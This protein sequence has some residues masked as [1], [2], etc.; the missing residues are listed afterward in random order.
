M[1]C[2]ACAPSTKT[3]TFFLC[4]ISAISA[5]GLTVPKTLETCATAISFVFSEI[6][7]G[8]FSICKTPLSEKGSLTIL[9]FFRCAAS[10]HGTRFEWCSISETIISSPLLIKASQKEKATRFTLSVVPFVKS[11]SSLDSALI[12]F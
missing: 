6:N 7:S 12:K 9:A 11:I 10:C 5:I 2:T 8:N 1:C 4:A 3:A